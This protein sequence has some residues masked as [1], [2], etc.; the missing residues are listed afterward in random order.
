[1]QKL[2]LENL[3]KLAPAMKEVIDY[4]AATVKTK[5]AESVA[6]VLLE[7]LQTSPVGGLPFVRLWGLEF[8]TR[9]PFPKLYAKAMKVAENSRESLGIRPIALIARANKQVQWARAQ[10]EK[11][12]NHAPWDRRAVIWS[13]SILPDDERKHWC[14]LIK[15]N[16]SDPLDR[17]VA[18]LTAQG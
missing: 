4:L 8:F 10:K 9:Q 6:K 11:W 17:A 2:A 18:L 3:T 5:D 7:H 12:N 14:G 13:G 15:D 1:L 16:S